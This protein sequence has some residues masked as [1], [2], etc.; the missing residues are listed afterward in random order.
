[1]GEIYNVNV[2]KRASSQVRL[3]AKAG[4]KA[5]ELETQSLFLLKRNPPL[6]SALHYILLCIILI[7]CILIS[8]LY[9]AL[10]IMQ[11]RVG[12]TE[13]L[14]SQEESAAQLCFALYSQFVKTKATGYVFHFNKLFTWCVK[15]ELQTESLLLLKRNLLYSSSL[16]SQ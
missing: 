11:S 13:S 5:A 4:G 6:N 12:D 2:E 3:Q 15:A 1:M 8:Y 7:L 16:Y 10:Y 14:S 9:F